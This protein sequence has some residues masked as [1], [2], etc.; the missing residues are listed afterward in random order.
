M[1]YSQIGL[2]RFF[3]FFLS[4][5]KFINLLL[6]YLWTKVKVII[7][8][9][10]SQKV[11][12][13]RFLY[14]VID[15]D[16]KIHYEF[17]NKG[18]IILPYHWS[19]MNPLRIYKNLPRNLIKRC[20]SDKKNIAGVLQLWIYYTPKGKYGVLRAAGVLQEYQRKGFLKKLYAAMDD[21]CLHDGINYVECETSVL[22]DEFKT[23]MGFIKTSPSGFWNTIST[24]LFR[25]RKYV[26]HYF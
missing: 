20:V 2:W 24:T 10:L 5:Q 18:H 7:A 26:K 12:N 1:L 9:K 14:I 15:S 11:T 16:G 6:P 21:F 8:E 25:Q 17:N 22:P 13:V 4:F 19:E 3:L 23:K